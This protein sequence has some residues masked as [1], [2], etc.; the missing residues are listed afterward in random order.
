MNLE[1]RFGTS[2]DIAC[3]GVKSIVVRDDSSARSIAS[4]SHLKLWRNNEESNLW[5]DRFDV[6]NELDVIELKQLHDALSK[7]QIAP[8]PFEYML[9]DSEA[10]YFEDLVMERFQ[11]LLDFKEEDLSREQTLSPINQPDSL[12]ASKD[13]TDEINAMGLPWGYQSDRTEFWVRPVREPYV[14]PL[15]WDVPNEIKLPMTKKQFDVIVHTVKNIRNRG[16][17][18]EILLKLK[19]S[20]TNPLFDFL[21]SDCD[22][23]ELF[24]YIK[25]ISADTFQT[26]LLLPTAASSSVQIDELTASNDVRIVEDDA[27]VEDDVIGDTGAVIEAPNALFLLGDTYGENSSSDTEGESEG[28]EGEG[29]AEDL[30]VSSDDC[31]LDYS[32]VNQLEVHVEPIEIDDKSDLDSVSTASTTS[33]PSESPRLECSDGFSVASISPTVIEATDDLLEGDQVDVEVSTVLSHPSAAERGITDSLDEGIGAASEPMLNIDTLQDAMEEGEVNESEDESAP[34]EGSLKTLIEESAMT[35]ESKD[36]EMD[37]EKVRIVESEPLKMAAYDGEDDG[38]GNRNGNDND[39]EET[40][41]KS[42]VSKSPRSAGADAESVQNVDQDDKEDENLGAQTHATSCLELTNQLN[43]LDTEATRLSSV[44]D[45]LLDD[46]VDQNDFWGK[47]FAI[48]TQSIEQ[49]REIAENRCKISLL[50][51]DLQT[52]L[53]VRKK[54]ADRLKRVKLLRQQFEEKAALDKIE[55]LKLKDNNLKYNV[56]DAI[57]LRDNDAESNSTDESSSSGE[58]AREKVRPKQRERRRSSSTDSSHDSQVRHRRKSHGRDREKDR[59]RS[60][61]R[62]RDKKRKKGKEK[63]RD[64]DRTRDHGRTRPKESEDLDLNGRTSR[65]KSDRRG[66]SDTATRNG[67]K[68]PSSRSRSRSRS[69]VRSRRTEDP[70]SLPAHEAAPTASALDFKDKIR[71]ALGVEPLKQ[72]QA[73]PVPFRDRIQMA[74]DALK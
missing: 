67:R 4:G 34:H 8:G 53:E 40:V 17:Q 68:R 72:P 28:G 12:E 51:S 10:S 29:E 37:S 55:A 61:S 7:A 69:L 21:N 39:D 70:A 25:R 1:D 41:N 14:V 23:H 48:K 64:R 49:L 20:D 45:D 44:E 56:L 60:R 52:A 73:A 11:D 54:K 63:E 31:N 18:F 13:V 36:N 35:L 5:I 47:P 62:A 15:I 50:I 3:T 24:E 33:F 71:V 19:E 46:D 30:V 59:R 16:S 26:G 65:I 74:L 32:N 58:K 38:N 27:Q 43:F 66:R 57:T 9:D 6:R 22:L 42:D 2:S